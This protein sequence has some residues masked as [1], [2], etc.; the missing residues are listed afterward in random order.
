MIFERK[1]RRYLAAVRVILIVRECIIANALTDFRSEKW[2]LGGVTVWRLGVS[3]ALCSGS[4][5][6][7]ECVA[8]IL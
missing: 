4:S 7:G 6:A 8:K 3:V 2:V 5:K 1:L